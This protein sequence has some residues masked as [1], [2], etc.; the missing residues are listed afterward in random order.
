MEHFK[1]KRFSNEAKK[2]KVSDVLL[3]DTL[4]DFLS[5]EANDQQKFSLGAGLYKLRLATKEGKGK[6]GGARSILA[7]RDGSRVVATLIF[8]K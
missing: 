4:N 1:V 6:S 2:D 8:E 5:M 7:F 3:F